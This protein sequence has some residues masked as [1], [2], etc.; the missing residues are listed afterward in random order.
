MRRT[1]LATV[2][3]ASAFTATGLAAV[4][5]AAAVDPDGCKSRFVY[6]PTGPANRPIGGA[7]KCR[8]EARGDL[9]RSRTMCS[10]IGDPGVPR[11]VYGPW[12]RQDGVTE[13]IGLCPDRTYAFSVTAEIM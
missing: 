7:S 2:A 3:I 10:L 12:V 13:S 8:P 11:A 9:V 5:P 4:Q 6:D 1:L